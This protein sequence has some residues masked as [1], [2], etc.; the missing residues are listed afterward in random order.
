MHIDSIK[1]GVFRVIGVDSQS[2]KK[3]NEG[4]DQR[5]RESVKMTIL[6]CLSVIIWYPGSSF[7]SSTDL[8]VIAQF[9]GISKVKAFN[10][11]FITNSR[12]LPIAVHYYILFTLL[13]NF[14]VPLLSYIDKYLG[15]IDGWESVYHNYDY[16]HLTTSNISLFMINL[17][18]YHGLYWLN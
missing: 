7:N 15:W 13:Y 9:Q 1:E 12:L 4:T 2:D 8:K 16:F 3:T 14:R 10:T 6:H 18:P 11:K 5:T 17:K